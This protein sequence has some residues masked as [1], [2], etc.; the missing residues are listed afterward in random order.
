MG[1]A[2]WKQKNTSIPQ[3]IG[4]ALQGI[5]HAYSS[6]MSVRTIVYIITVYIVGSLLFVPTLMN[7]GVAISFSLLWLVIELLNTSIEATVDR[8]GTK[9]NIISKHAKDLAAGA[10]LTMEFIVIIF[11]IFTVA[12]TYQDYSSWV[13]DGGG[14]VY[15]YIRYTF[16]ADSH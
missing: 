2:N 3:K 13:R 12:H 10:G 5:S 11:S 6:D 16:H 9:Y 4:Y 7:K 1:T 8:I 15:E 14:D